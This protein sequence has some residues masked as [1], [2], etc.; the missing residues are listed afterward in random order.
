MR[1]DRIRGLT[2]AA[3]LWTVAAIGL[4]VGGGLYVLA[5]GATA[6]VFAVLAG[7]KPVERHLWM[8]TR[9]RVVIVLADTGKVSLSLLEAELV[10]EGI[11][12]M[13]AVIE[14][15]PD[16]T[17]AEIRLAVARPPPDVL[18]ALLRRLRAVDGVRSVRVGR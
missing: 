11:P 18:D 3:S 16:G 2:T 6:V 1:R 10:A 8:R 13:E 17:E 9:G 15:G 12:I 5:L 4:A 14:R 7:I